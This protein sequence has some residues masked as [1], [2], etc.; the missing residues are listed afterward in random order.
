MFRYVTCDTEDISWFVSNYKNTVCLFYDWGI[1]R[2][3]FICKFWY[4]ISL[5]QTSCGLVS[6]YRSDRSC[7]MLFLVS[8]RYIIAC[9]LSITFLIYWN[10]H[11]YTVTYWGSY[12]C[13]PMLQQLY[14]LWT[15]IPLCMTNSHICVKA[16]QITPK[17][18]AK[19]TK[20]LFEPF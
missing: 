16:N 19:Y 13:N 9:I 5:Y 6:F 17:N 2:L 8:W 18:T 14:T 15:S 20:K 12:T 11:S 1:T 4:K 10:L 7:F 3:W